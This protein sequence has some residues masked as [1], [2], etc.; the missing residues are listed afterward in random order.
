MPQVTLL[1][2]RSHSQTRAHKLYRPC[3]KCTG[4]FHA[5]VRM[6]H[7]VWLPHPCEPELQQHWVLNRRTTAALLCAVFT[8]SPICH[9]TTCYEGRQPLITR[10]PTKYSSSGPRAPVLICLKW[11]S[12]TTGRNPE[13]LVRTGQR[14]TANCLRDYPRALKECLC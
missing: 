4:C 8:D 9:R 14:A 13:T 3:W 6:C 10:S 1:S 7:G 2:R 11:W 12:S 5:A